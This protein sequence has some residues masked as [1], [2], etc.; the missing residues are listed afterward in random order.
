VPFG[1]EQGPMVHCR[2][3]VVLEYVDVPL[4]VLTTVTVH[5]SAVVAPAVPATWVLHWSTDM[6]EAW[7]VVGRANPA[8]VN[9]PMSTSRAISIVPQVC[10][11]AGIG[12]V[13]VLM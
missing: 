3:T 6:V 2:V 4:I 1:D 8:M 5:F 13:S 12:F 9:V 10:R 7:A 11:G